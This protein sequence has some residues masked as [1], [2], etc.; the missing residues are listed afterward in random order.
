MSA[1]CL[2]LSEN[3]EYS[4]SFQ[5]RTKSLEAFKTPSENLWINSIQE[6]CKK[7]IQGNSLNQRIVD[8]LRLENTGTL[9]SPSP[10][11]NPTHHHHA[12]KPCSI[13]T[14]SLLKLTCQLESYA[15]H[16]YIFDSNQLTST[17]LKNRK[18]HRTKRA[19]YHWEEDQSGFPTQGEAEFLLIFLSEIQMLQ[20][21]TF[22]LILLS[23]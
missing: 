17:F 18:Q 6:Y 14:P 11:V 23:L 3:H 7:K 4:M 2:A 12:T 13:Y 8:S 10:T 16:T 19:T 20:Q 1:W 5:P 22:C 15:S 21:R 9:G